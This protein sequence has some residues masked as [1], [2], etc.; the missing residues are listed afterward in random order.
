MFQETADL[1]ALSICR[2]SDCADGIRAEDH[3]ACIFQALQQ[4]LVWMAV[5]IYS[6]AD[7]SIAGFYQIKEFPVGRK[8]AAMMRDLQQGQIP[9]QPVM[10][11][12]HLR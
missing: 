8:P 7:H 9:A 5:I 1:H 2:D 3:G 11:L 6:A 12:Y 4:F 10:V